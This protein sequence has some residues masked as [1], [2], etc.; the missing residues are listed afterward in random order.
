MTELPAPVAEAFDATNVGDLDRFVGAFAED[1]VIDDW[2]R[3]FRGRDE[4]AG[5]SRR[6]SIGV[7]QT[8]DVT[9]VRTA[10]D[11]VIVAADVGGDGFNGPSTFTFRLAPGGAAIE[12]MTITG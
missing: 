2:G 6:E 4:I 8:F 11:V 5:W 9:D 10:G 7:N 12:R 3:E 1:G